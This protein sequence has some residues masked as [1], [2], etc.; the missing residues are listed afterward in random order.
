MPPDCAEDGAVSKRGR[1][2]ADEVR[3]REEEALGGRARRRFGYAL[4][5]GRPR[6][7]DGTGTAD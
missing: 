6:C 7:E 5:T 4:T 1:G 3:A 2:V